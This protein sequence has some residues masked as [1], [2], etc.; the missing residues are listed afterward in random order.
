MNFSPVNII[1]ILIIWQSLLFAVVLATPAYNKNKSN[2]FLSLLLL[3][4][5]VHFSYNLLYTNGLFLD[6]LPRYSCSYGFLYGPLFYLYIQFYLEKD[7][8][9]DKWRWLHFVP[10]FGILVVTAFGY[11]ICK[12]AGFF[13]FP[14][15]LAYAFFSFRELALYSR[16]IPHVSSKSVSSEIKW[17]KTLSVF[18]L[19]I[20]L[21]D[22]LAA[23]IHIINI[24]NINVKV[25]VVVQSGILLFV[26]LINYQGLKNPRPYQQIS[27]SD[28]ALSK[29][30]ELKVPMAKTDKQALQDLAASLDQYMT[31]TRPY[32]NPDL[33]INTLAFNLGV[34]E[35]TL[36]QTINS[37]MG[38]NFSD[39][40][41][42]YRIEFVRQKLE[43]DKDR[44]MSIKEVMYEA[45][46]NSRSVF[47]TA[48]KK[49]T[50][51][52]PSEY[53]KYHQ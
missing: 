29:A 42:S 7:A 18:M 20:V 38:A 19:V 50:G 26:S 52:T 15:M 35:K 13:I 21:L 49:K 46:F 33:N 6:V 43:E 31:E 53:Q 5:A 32:L 22:L 24:F 11:K 14:A 17:L 40:I 25:E 12:W 10:F 34:T 9:L 39:Y 41:N 3:T 2:L 51:L 28:I 30:S 27:E 48:F 36:S 8:K 45:G 1:H 23:Q 16:T 44:S 4:L 47:N 37:I